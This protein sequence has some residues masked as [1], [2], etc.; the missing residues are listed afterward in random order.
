MGF[1]DLSTHLV[2]SDNQEIRLKLELSL[3]ISKW[4]AWL[5]ATN[6]IQIITFIEFCI[7]TK[8]RKKQLK[9][10]RKLQNHIEYEVIPE[11]LDI[12]LSAAKS[13]VMELDLNSIMKPNDVRSIMQTIYEQALAMTISKKWHFGKQDKAI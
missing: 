2:S 6:L 11:V 10:R 3:E 7:R 13:R 9:L 5:I 12:V 1:Y 8:F 4:I